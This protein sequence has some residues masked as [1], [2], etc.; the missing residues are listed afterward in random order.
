MIHERPLPRFPLSHAVCVVV[1]FAVVAALIAWVAARYG[2]SILPVALFAIVAI[3]GYFYYHR[4]RCPECGNRLVVR[5]D[6]VQGTQQFRLL[7][8]C[9]RCQIAWDTGHIGDESSSS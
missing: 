3:I 1:S 5:R 9:P 7:L 4:R 6:Y 2:I 8:D